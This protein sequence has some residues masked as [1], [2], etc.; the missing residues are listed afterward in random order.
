MLIDV[1]VDHGCGR[2]GSSTAELGS[3]DAHSILSS[4]KR[5]EPMLAQACRFSP[6]SL[7]A[8]S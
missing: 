3:F 4:R 8:H 2:I 5:S 6:R 1:V 7:M